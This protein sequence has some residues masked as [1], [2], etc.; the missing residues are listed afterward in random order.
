MESSNNISK[1]TLNIS[2]CTRV[3]DRP[4]LHMLYALTPKNHQPVS[5][6][7]A[8]DLL[9]KGSLYIF[10]T[11]GDL[12]TFSEPEKFVVDRDELNEETPIVVY[13]SVELDT[14]AFVTLLRYAFEFTPKLTSDGQD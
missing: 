9:K 1:A 8:E 3:K 4:T 6:E 14:L 11:N 12:E 7:D 10:L 13:D 2:F 5:I